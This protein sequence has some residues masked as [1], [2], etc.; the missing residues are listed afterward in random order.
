MKTYVMKQKIGSSKQVVLDLP[1]SSAY[2]RLSLTSN[3]WKPLKFF[4]QEAEIDGGDETPPQHLQ[5]C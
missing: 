1:Q 4:V 5:G 3:S 2:Q